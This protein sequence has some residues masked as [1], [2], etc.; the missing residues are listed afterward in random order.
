V[1]FGGPNSNNPYYGGGGA[2]FAGVVMGQYSTFFLFDCFATNNA[3]NGG[4]G[5]ELDSASSG[6]GAPVIGQWNHLVCTF[7]GT[8]ESM[9]I[10]GVNVKNKTVTANGA[11]VNFAPDLTTPLLIGTGPEITAQSGEG[12]LD[13]YGVIDE[14]AIY[15]E[16]LPSNSIV[17]HYNAAHTT[18]YPNVVLQDN[19]VLYYRFNDTITMANS[20]YP[21]NTFPVATNYGTLGVSANGLYQP[22]TAPGVAGPPYAGFS[23]NTAVAINGW[24]GAVDVGGSNLPSVLNPVGKVPLT[25]VSWFQGNSADAPSRYQN[26]VGHGNNSY[27]LALGTT[28]GE[29]RFN[30]YNTELQFVNATDMITNH[31]ADNDGNWHMAAGVSDGTNAYMYLDGV[32]CKSTNSGTG[33]NIPGS[34]IDLLLG[35][36][37]DST[38]ANFNTANTVRN[39]DG[40]IAQVAF[41]NTNLTTAQIQSLF[42]AAGIP[43]TIL[44]QS[45]GATNNAGT[46]LSVPVQFAGSQ[47]ITYQWY[48]TNGSSVAG[49]TNANLTYASVPTNAIGNFYVIGTSPYGSVT[50]AVVTVYVYGSPVV[51][52]Q[53]QTN[54]EIFAGSTPVLD[55]VASGAAPILYQWYSNNVLIAGATASTYS[56]PAVGAAAT[57]TCTLSNFV[58]G[59]VTISPISLT[60]LPAPTAPY[61][62]TV[63][64][65]HPLAFWR[66]DESAG[67][68]AYDYVGG[69]NGTYTNV[70][71]GEFPSY[72]PTSD[73]SE[74][75]A[76][77]F[78]YLQTNNS[79]VGWVPTNINFASP[80]NVN[81]EFSVECWVQEKGFAVGSGIVSIGYG[82]GGEEFA[83]DCGASNNDLRFFVR[84]AGG[85]PEN[86]S[87]SVSTGDQAWHYVAGVCDEANGKVSLYVDGTLASTANISAKS[88]ILTSIQPLTIGARQESLGSQYDDQWIGSIDEVAVYNY[89]LTAAQVQSHYLAYGFAPSTVQVTPSTETVNLGSTATFTAL[90]NG[91]PPQYYQWYDVNNNPISTNATLVLSNVQQSAQGQYTVVVTN[92]YGTDAAYPY[93]SVNL[94][95]PGL[96]QDISPLTQTV[97]LY[98]GLDTINYTFVVSGS[99]PF[100]YQ[101]Y[102]NGTKV[103]GATN[104]TYTF[105]A[106][107][108]TNTYYVQVTN[109]DTASQAGG[110][111]LQSSTATVIGLTMP[112]LNPGN[113][114]DRVKISFPGY[115][116]Q[117]LTNFPA[118]ITL[119]PATIPGMS[120]S[121]FTGN[122]TDL[123]FTDATGTAMLPYE[124][125][126]WNDNGL[127]TIWVEIPVLNG[128]NIWAYWGNPAD[129]DVSPASTNVWLNANYQI[130]YHL[131]ESALPFAD[132]TGQYP[133]TNGVIPTPT[134][135]VVGHGANFNGADYLTPGHVTLSNQFTAYAWTYIS[136]SAP[137]NEQSIWVNQVGGYGANGFSWFVN[138]YQTSDQE[139][140]FDCGNGSGTGADKIIG[141]EAPGQWHLMVSTWDQPNTAVTSYIDGTL[142]G[143][144]TAPAFGVFALTNQLNLGS[145]LNPVLFFD[146][147]MDEARIQGGVASTNW[148]ETTY[149]NMSE[150]SFVSYSSV[151]LEPTLALVSATNGY[152]FSWTTNGGPFKLETTTSL[153]Q[154]RTWATVTTP[155]AVVTNG[156]WQQIVQPAAGSHFYRLQGQ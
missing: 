26:I 142:V 43:P 112:Q 139:Q 33:I 126:E 108:G 21:T 30:P 134:N 75:N 156:V 67:T 71:V 18:N 70:L 23:S 79:Y 74:G 107:A 152:I 31:A 121:Q 145:F 56:P 146:G 8:N 63:L 136:P 46:P 66:L 36:A 68:T 10:N 102:Q 17:N 140:H 47:P 14:V 95:P 97:Q 49:Q 15:K 2:S 1:N 115:T 116:G 51:Q 25:V 87:S 24:F 16:I 32:L 34:T 125:D 11:G 130:V 83:L 94:G 104:S 53:T 88:G 141:S 101:W 45:P 93:L 128:T 61:P 37:P 91:T 113:Y 147:V 120:Y 41:W 99:L 124:I 13:F 58:S 64:G 114:A 81:A 137:A 40:Q 59:N 153:D 138:S 82:S 57:Y 12:G 127:S 131:K 122:G 100:A 155:P 77:Y 42:N 62:A 133:A 148:I 80:T 89:A 151:N 150:S 39:F 69:N 154:P 52:G 38:T 118:L 106:V 129:T 5:N 44:S 7:D 54:L 110:I 144:A 96:V 109:V 3:V 90:G 73:P 98:S 29:N 6:A 9:W 28:C 135:G 27:R 78:G 132:S 65:D 48:S 4:K 22:G 85:T 117:P 123:R 86:A 19:P 35:G 149:L 119:N 143:S 103:A 111:P 76:P 84:N 72:D 50:S 92:V 105:T 60:V 55:V 20:G